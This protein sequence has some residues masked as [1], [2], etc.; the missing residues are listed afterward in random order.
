MGGTVKLQSHPKYAREISTNVTG[1]FVL[2]QLVMLG[3]VCTWERFLPKSSHSV[4][5]RVRVIHLQGSA[6]FCISFLA[7]LSWPAN[8][9]SLLSVVPDLHCV[10]WSLWG[11]VDPFGIPMGYGGDPA[12]CPLHHWVSWRKDSC[13]LVLSVSPS[14]QAVA[15]GGCSGD[16]GQQRVFLDGT[17]IKGKHKISMELCAW[18]CVHACVCSCHN[19]LPVMCVVRCSSS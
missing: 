2:Q 14:L 7:L 8:T 17:Y 1:D 4:N 5:L 6:A 11:G 10:L 9:C 12:V 18:V 19:M 15:C 3:R 13:W 16:T